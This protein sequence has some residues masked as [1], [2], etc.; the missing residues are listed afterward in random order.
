MNSRAGEF[1]ILGVP[2]EIYFN[3]FEIEYKSKIQEIIKL[4]FNKN[5]NVQFQIVS[6]TLITDESL[7]EA[8]KSKLY[9]M[10]KTKFSGSP[11]FRSQVELQS[12]MEASKLQKAPDWQLVKLQS[13]PDKYGVENVATFSMFDSRFFT[14][15][16]DKRKKIRN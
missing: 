8:P 3:R 12:H 11:Y 9:S 15:P 13:M 14:Y 16:N 1:L 5:V 6:S 4:K 2:N 10:K 7:T